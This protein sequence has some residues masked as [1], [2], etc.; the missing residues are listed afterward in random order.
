MHLQQADCEP[1]G[2]SNPFPAQQTHCH[3]LLSP[4]SSKLCHVIPCMRN[5]RATHTGKFTLQSHPNPALNPCVVLM[6]RQVGRH[7][8]KAQPLHTTTPLPWMCSPSGGSWPGPDA[9]HVSAQ[10]GPVKQ[11]PILLQ[12]KG[13]QLKT[14]PCHYWHKH[15][16]QSLLGSHTS[17]KECPSRLYRAAGSTPSPRLSGERKVVKKRYTTCWCSGYHTLC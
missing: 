1:H 10:S 16:Q 2:C 12:V 17:V 3:N 14:Q 6:G 15:T 7:C 13:I 9:C 5:L 11:M 8:C 4:T